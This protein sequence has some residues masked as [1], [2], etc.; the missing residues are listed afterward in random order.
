MEIKI[1]KINLIGPDYNSKKAIDSFRDVF[2][3][4]SR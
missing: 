1:Q 3:F 4:L 2:P